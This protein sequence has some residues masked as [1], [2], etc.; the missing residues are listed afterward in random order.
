MPSTS[1]LITKLSQLIGYSG[2]CSHIHNNTPNRQFHFFFVSL[3]LI[4]HILAYKCSIETYK[5]NDF[6]LCQLMASDGDWFTLSM[7]L[8][9]NTALFGVNNNNYY[10]RV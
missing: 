4:H 8:N 6:D 3:N 9:M 2:F 1:Y 10:M 5:R 7:I